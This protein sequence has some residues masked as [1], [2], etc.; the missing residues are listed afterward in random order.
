MHK[1]LHE[2]IAIALTAITAFAIIYANTNRKP[3]M[4]QTE[5]Q[6]RDFFKRTGLPFIGFTFES[7]MAVKAIR[8]AITCGAK[9]SNQGQPAPVQ[10][11]LI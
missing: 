4:T 2:I 3:P 5:R 11:G 9:A 10:P 7:A 1:L 8:I 6:Q